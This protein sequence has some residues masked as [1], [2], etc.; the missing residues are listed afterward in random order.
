VTD[1]RNSVASI[2]Q[3]TSRVGGASS[4]IFSDPTEGLGIKLGNVDL[5]QLTKV[6][7]KIKEQLTPALAI[8]EMK[9]AEFKNVGDQVTGALRESPLAITVQV[10]MPDGSTQDRTF[11]GSPSDLSAAQNVFN[12]AHR[13]GSI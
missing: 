13:L 4:P 12:P 6:R 10:Q 8:P 3:I 11:A 2:E 9:T 1:T 5:G 7:D